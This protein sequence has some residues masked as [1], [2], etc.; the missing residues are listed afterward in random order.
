LADATRASWPDGPA[1]GAAAGGAV[2]ESLTGP[3]APCVFDP[4]SSRLR[5]FEPESSEFCAEPTFAAA[6]TPFELVEACVETVAGGVE[7]V[8]AVLA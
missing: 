8:A 5:A 6:W 7:T 2:P 3:P 1:A 4:E